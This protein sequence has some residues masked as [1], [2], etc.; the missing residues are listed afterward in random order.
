MHIIQKLRITPRLEVRPVVKEG[1]NGQTIK[2]VIGK[3]QGAYD[4]FNYN[5]NNDILNKP[6]S[7]NDTDKKELE[8]IKQ[9]LADD[10]GVGVDKLIA[11]KLSSVLPLG[12][13]YWIFTFPPSLSF[14]NIT[15]SSRNIE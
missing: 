13:L 5:V 4:R 8:K 1:Q 15:I 7:Y 6:A 12:A 14:L 2:T 10:L 9:E 11:K 3:Q